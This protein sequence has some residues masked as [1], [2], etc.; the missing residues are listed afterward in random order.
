MQYNIG[1][2]TYFSKNITDTLKTSINLGMYST[3]FFMGNPR[4]FNRTE[5]TK[6]DIDKSKNILSR[7]PMHIFTHFPYIANLAGSVDV[8][9]WSGDEKQDD[10]TNKI[11]ESLEYELNILSQ[12]N[13]NKNGVVIHPGNHK[14][15]KEG[16]LAISKS[17]NKINFL[18]DANL[19]LENSAGQGYSLAT[20]LDEIK[21]ILDN[22]E[23]DKKRNIGICI[24][25][26][27]IFAYGEYDIR[28][29]NGVEK[30]FSDIDSKI[31]LDKFKLLHLN[32]SMIPFGGRV[33]RHESIGNG[34]IW[35]KSTESLKYLLD[36]CKKHDIPVILETET[37]IQDMFTISNIK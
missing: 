16:L 3:Q 34:Y 35:K 17:I 2:H 12:I 37:S 24:D 8:L 9:A 22:V 6:S 10:K 13:S 20:T 26:C 27:H 7:Y 32:D 23:N 28:D 36:K 19:L 21:L 29:K 25:T 15:R 4:G 31:G 30:L 18:N 14:N 1:A 11:I 5:I 33:D